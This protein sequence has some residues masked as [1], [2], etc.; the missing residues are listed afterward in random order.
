MR[1]RREARLSRVA[2]RTGSHPSALLTFTPDAHRPLP[3]AFDDHHSTRMSL[4]GP[5]SRKGGGQKSGARRN[6]NNRIYAHPLPL[7]CPAPAPGHIL[8]LFGLSTARLENPHC[9][10]VFDPATRSVWVTN[11]KDSTILWRRGFFGK[12]DLSRS[13]PS[14]LARQVNTRKAAGKCTRTIWRARAIF[15]HVW[16]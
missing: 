12:G 14:W 10:G 1:G 5:S 16:A 3:D 7:V 4:I 8:G 9:E 13:E 2:S 6:E 15:A 11:E